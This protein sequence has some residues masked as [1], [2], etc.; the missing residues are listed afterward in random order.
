MI[1]ISSQVYR[2]FLSAKGDLLKCSVPGGEKKAGFLLIGEGGVSVPNLTLC[3]RREEL[4]I[5]HVFKTKK[6]T[7][8]N[9]FS[10]GKRFYLI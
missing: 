5:S 1:I 6:I 9:I 10:L 8:E 4:L 7:F 3:I 2:A